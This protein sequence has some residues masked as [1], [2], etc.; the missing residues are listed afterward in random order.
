[1]KK[2][3]LL[4]IIFTSIWFYSCKTSLQIEK[5]KESYLPSNLSPAVSELPLQVQ[6]DVKKME[7]LINAK[8]SGLI[9]EGSNIS[10]QDLSIKVWKAQNFTFT[11]NNNIIEYQVPLKV[12]SQFAWKI[13]KFGVSLSDHYEATGTILLTYKTTINLNNKW[14]LVSNTSSSGFKWIETPKLNI[15]GISVPVTPIANLALNQ[16]D[17]LITNQIDKALAQSID[18]KK[19]VSQVW[20]EVQKPRLVNADNNLWIRISPHDILL[21]PFTTSGNKLKMTIALSA[22]IETFLGA[23]PDA[24]TP[25]KLPDLK[26]I[27]RPPQ[28]FNLNIAADV[29]F[30]KITEIA[31]KMLKDKTFKEGNKSITIN[32]LS[33]FGSNG[34]AVFV[35]D[36]SGSLKGRIYFTGNMIFNPDKNTVEISEPEFDVKTQ[37]AL[38]KSA[39]WLMHGF[40]LKQLAPYLTYSV[41]D[42]LEQMKKEANQMLAN[43]QVYEGITFQGNLNNLSVQNLSL[44]PGAVRLQA[45]LKGNIAMQI[46]DL[47]F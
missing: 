43:Y 42:N 23:Q 41:K 33:I 7:T 13:E 27:N 29:T 3:H 5:P 6:L 26:I 20:T 4:I 21:T 12:W 40:I 46:Q 9:Y 24:N 22:G 19:Y 17:R 31:K 15:V 14:E 44:V 38:I 1:M 18:L 34:K 11:I 39:S 30:D 47:K 8:M 35:A 37:N 28:Q 10:N 25:V 45:N 36:V 16:C 32:D 2:L